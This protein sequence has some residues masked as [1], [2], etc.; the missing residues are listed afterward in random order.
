MNALAGEFARMVVST[1]MHLGVTLER[2]AVELKG[3]AEQR[4]A[5]LDRIAGQAGFQDA[6]D[7]EAHNVA[8]FAAGQIVKGA[9][10]ADQMLVDNIKGLLA[11]AVKAAI[12]LA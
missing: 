7:A 9:D 10:V 8:L 4:M 6:V 12:L 5:H 1:A 3:Y 11:M 2:D